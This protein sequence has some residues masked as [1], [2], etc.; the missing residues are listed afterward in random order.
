MRDFRLEEHELYMR[1]RD[2]FSRT[3]QGSWGRAA[4]VKKLDD[5]QHKLL[6]ERKARE[7]QQETAK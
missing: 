2:F 6:E 7:N 3:R 4:V 1:A 5:L